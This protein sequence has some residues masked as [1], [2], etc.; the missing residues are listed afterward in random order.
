M[1][2]VHTRTL[3]LLV[4]WTKKSKVFTETIVN[5]AKMGYICPC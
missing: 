4:A 2:N 5:G 3:I 1:Y